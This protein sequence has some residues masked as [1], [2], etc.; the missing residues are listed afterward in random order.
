MLTSQ[1]VIS[2][3]KLLLGR[4]PE[5]PAI[6]ENYIKHSNFDHLRRTLLGSGEFAEKL[7]RDPRFLGVPMA[8]L[9]VTDEVRRYQG[10]LEVLVALALPVWDQSVL[11]VGGEL[12]NLA[13][14]FLDRQCKVSVEASAE[15]V[16]FLEKVVSARRVHAANMSFGSHDFSSPIDDD[17][18]GR[19]DL[20]YG[21]LPDDSSDVM[22]IWLDNAAESCTGTLLV[23]CMTAPG[24]SEDIF[25]TPSPRPS[26]QFRTI[27][28]KKWI[29]TR[30][31]E[32]FE[33]IYEPMQAPLESVFTQG[34][35]GAT[36]ETQAMYLASRAPLSVPALKEYVVNA[37]RLHFTSNEGAAARM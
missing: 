24:R 16:G 27:A 8:A 20:V 9:S 1:D 30:L 21:Q 15:T 13:G 5:S 17:S 11:I 26:Q 28:T 31:R 19:F 29:F 6:I 32:R 10:F 2:A 33:H 12:A 35:P 4:E 36:I 18:L 22:R 25:V 3:Y 34:G 37:S 23:A 14:F 7:S